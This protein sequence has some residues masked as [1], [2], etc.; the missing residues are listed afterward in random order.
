MQQDLLCAL[1]LQEYGFIDCDLSELFGSLQEDTPIEIARKQ[2]RE[3]LVYEIAKAVDK[4]KA[5]TGLKLEGL[6]TKHGEIAKGAQQ[7]INLREVEMKQVQIG[8]QGNEVDLRELWLTAYGYEILTALGMGLT[9]NLEGLGRIRTALGELRFDL[10]TGETSVSGVKMRKSLKKAIWW[11][12][13][14]RGRPWS[15]IQ[16]LKN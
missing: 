14:N 4:N 15:E 1:G 2:V 11:I 3:A 16:D 7:I 13:R 5:T 6:L 10:E 8:V 9:T 12:V